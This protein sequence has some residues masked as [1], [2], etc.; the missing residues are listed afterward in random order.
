MLPGSYDREVKAKLLAV[1]PYCLR[2]ET[3]VWDS[4]GFLQVALTY[5]QEHTEAHTPQINIIKKIM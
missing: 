4:Q 2:P 1:N 3:S 5:A